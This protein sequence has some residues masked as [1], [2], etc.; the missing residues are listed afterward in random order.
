MA[1][2][3]VGG[4]VDSFCT[5]CKMLLAHTILAMVGERIARVRC[6]TCMG[7]HAYKAAPGTSKPRNTSSGGAKSET[8]SRS[9]A[10]SFD[11]QLAGKDGSTARSYNINEK[12]V[13]DQVVDHPTFGR[14]FV[15]AARADKIDVVFKSFVKTLVH[16]RNGK[17][18][19]AR[20]APTGR[21][22][23]EPDVEAAVV[24]DPAQPETGGTGGASA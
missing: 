17:P 20:P 11:E 7:E 21:P 6:N 16:A 14:G 9:A 13:V 3:S 22:V 10:A 2:H 4:E 12:F 19:P 18:A 23:T 24:A 5:K 8:R 1:A 15:A